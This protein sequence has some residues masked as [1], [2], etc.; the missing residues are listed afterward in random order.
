MSRWD[1]QDYHQHSSQQQKWAAEL[2]S[3]LAFVGDERVLDIGCGDGK[4]TALIARDVPRGCV[5]GIDQSPE[6]IGFA[7]RHFPG[8][9]FPNLRFEQAQAQELSFDAQFDW[10]VSFACLHWVIDHRP[11]LAA[12][13]RSLR[14]GGRI[15]L[16]F[17]GRGNAAEIARSVAAV[18]QRPEWSGYFQAMDYP[19]RFYSAEEYRP[20]LVQAQLLPKRVELVPKDMVHQGP[21]T[22]AGWLRTAWIPYVQR[23]P[24]ALQQRFLDVMVASYMEDHPADTQGMIHVKMV[25][26]EVEA[27]KAVASVQV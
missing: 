12:I 26:L 13:H 17:G 14:P 1:A 6:M 24:E 8:S 15:M 25:R 10:V 7:Q 21:G 19:W 3:R 23:V 22:L 18:T 2:L 5:V 20:W 27:E 16:Q 11:V 4:V 9:D